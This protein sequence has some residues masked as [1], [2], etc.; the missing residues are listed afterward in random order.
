M[1]HAREMRGEQLKASAV[2]GLKVSADLI[3]SLLPDLKSQKGW[4]LVVLSTFSVS[5][6]STANSQVDVVFA[7]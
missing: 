2:K 3:L 6:L 4:G 1:Y 5:E 7:E